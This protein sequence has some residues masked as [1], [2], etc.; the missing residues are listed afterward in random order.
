MTLTPTAV[1]ELSAQETGTAW[2][3]LLT[4]SHPDMPVPLR[5]T[6]DHVP[7]TSGGQVYTPYP[8]EVSPPDDV[9]GRAPMATLRVDNTSQQVIAVLRG[10]EKPPSVTIQIVRASDPNVVEVIYDGLEL[11]GENY[12]IGA[13][14]GKLTVDDWATEEFPYVTFDKR[15]IGLFP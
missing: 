9:E 6:S 11:R 3:V 12:D 2:L 7:T 5:M 1:A 14:T 15:F 4:I 13:I 10:L 8:F